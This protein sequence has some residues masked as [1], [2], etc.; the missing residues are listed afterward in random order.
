MPVIT[1]Q[2]EEFSINDIVRQVFVPPNHQMIVH[3]N[4]IIEERLFL[5]GELII[6]L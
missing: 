5:E 3:G 1:P 6:E 2:T 4:L